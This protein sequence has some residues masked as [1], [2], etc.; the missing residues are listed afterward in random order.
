MKKQAESNGWY[1]IL[2]EPIGLK[3]LSSKLLRAHV[4]PSEDLN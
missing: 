2:S 4:A 3:A 1:C